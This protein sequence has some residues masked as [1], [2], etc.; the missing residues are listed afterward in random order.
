MSFDVKIEQQRR[1]QWRPSAM[2]WREYH[3]STKHSIESLSRALHVLDW[4]NLPDPFRH[5]EGVPVLDLPADPPIPETPALRVLDGA[6]GALPAHDGSTFLSQLL[7]YSAAIS[8]S[9]RVPSTGHRYALR[10]NPSS[11]NLHP[12]EFH[13]LTRGLRAWPDGLYHYRPSAHMAEQRALGSLEMKVSGN[14]API[15]LVLTSIAWREAWKYRDRAYRYCLH[16]IGHAWQAL[17]LAA[18][19]IGCDSF[20]VGAFPDDGVAQFCRLN[21]DEWPMLIVELRGGSI[22]VREPDA[23][24][25][26]WYGGHANQLSRES[27]A[28]PRID[29]IHGATKVTRH[30]C[31]G[32]STDGSA[33]TGSGEIKLP[34][35]ASSKRAFGEVARMR[36]S[37][38]DFVGGMQAMSL[39]QLSAI[40]AVTSR[41]LFADFAGARFIQLYLYAHRVDGLQPGVYRLWPERAELEQVR[42]GDQ[43]VAAAGLSLGQDLAGNAC[44]AFSMIGDLERAVR[45][46]GDRGYRYVHFEAGAIGHCLYLA[47]EALGLGATGIGAFYDEEVNRYLNLTSDRGQV[48]YHFAIGYPVPDLRLE[49]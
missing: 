11:G 30:T 1:Y 33:S 46:H 10:V 18:R 44:V 16:D 38:V 37:A 17:A 31:Q 19:A 21:N 45:A 48:V 32:I 28:C 34:P 29:G 36:R 3:E 47:A 15:V 42:S 25:T 13:F 40:L 43:R 5:Y 14:S 9:K 26:V 12:T 7:F 35:P 4:A 27:S 8:A 2:T 22:P 23:K 41:P 49:A 6:A 39:V 24:G 20:A